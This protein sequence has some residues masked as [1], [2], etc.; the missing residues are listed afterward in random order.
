MT[1]DAEQAAAAHDLF[2]ATLK[3]AGDKASDDYDLVLRV[4]DMALADAVAAL[5]DAS[6]PS[7]LMGPIAPALVLLAPDTY[8]PPLDRGRLDEAQDCECVASCADAPA[9]GCTLS[10][11]RHVHPKDRSGNFGP[12]PVHPVAPGDH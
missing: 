9:T 4:D 10:G 12:C 6:L 2:D 3:A 11:T 8:A 7:N 5:R 1:V